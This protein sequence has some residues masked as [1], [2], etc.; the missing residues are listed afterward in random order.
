MNPII[1]LIANAQPGE[2]KFMLFVGAGVSKDAGVPTAWD[3]MLKTASLLYAVENKEI[4]ENINYEEWFLNSDY[5]KM[6][7][8]EL[9]EKVYST[10]QDQQDFLQQ[11]LSSAKPGKVHELIAELARREIIRVIIT[12]NFDQYIEDSLKEKGLD[13]QV[14]STEEDLKNSEPLIQCKKM[15]IYKP[16]GDLGKGK[17][18][19]TPA[20]LE[21]LPLQIEDELVRVLSEHGVMVLGYSGRD[22]DMQ[23]VFEKRN[24]NYYQLFWINPKPPE[25]KMKNI[26][27]SKGY[28]YIECTGASQFLESFFDLVERIKDIAPPI[29]SGPTVF[30]LENALSS[31]KIVV[32]PLF[33]DFLARIFNDLEQTKPDFS[34]FEEM[35][36][37][38][39]YQIKKG[40][41]ISYDFIYAGL[42]ASK[43]NNLEAIK[44]IYN[45]FGNFL[46]LYE[47]T[48]TGRY[49][50]I[51]YDGFKFLAY[52]MFVSFIAGL[53]KYERW[54]ALDDLLSTDIFVDKGYDSGYK[55]FVRVSE[56]MQSLDELRNKRLY[57]H[58]RASVVA[59]FIK[60]R[61]SESK[62]S[63][64][65]TFK[66]F[67]ETDYFLFVRSVCDVGDTD[68][69]YNIWY[70]QSFVYLSWVPKYIMMAESKV[71][72]DKLSKAVGFDNSEDFKVKFKGRHE[73]IIK[74]SA[75][76]LLWVDPLWNYDFDKLGSRK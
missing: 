23:I 3:L 34:K 24:Y 27:E 52:E 70:P 37:A 73:K 16:H 42:L 38:I 40:L 69:L 41:Q 31:N 39:V 72:L 7:Y 13:I 56:G 6:S 61:F 14:I 15:R 4:K 57:Q 33:S 55:S 10:N 45:Y 71:F 2:K 12:T 32:T 44:T 5:E 65:I 67:V 19:N 76:G 63:E 22:K 59:D 58:K 60:S 21:R 18:R 26:L 11:Y 36:D 64:L 50:T 53:I 62:L 47:P 30:D 25:G 29:G 48:T 17:L 74:Y 66:E 1:K 49:R 9:I 43:Y 28:E 51:D 35:D 20:D 54:E 75:W 8:S 46:K 68:D